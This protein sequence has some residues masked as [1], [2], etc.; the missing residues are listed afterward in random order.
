MNLPWPRVH[1]GP[2]AQ[3]PARHDFSTC[4][5]PA[6]PCPAAW[7][8]VQAA[9]VRH[10]PDPQH[11]A[12]RARL[13]QWHQV[14][15][16]R[17]LLAASA[18]EFIQRITAAALALA[19]GPVQL[20]RQAYG[21]YAAA[22]AAWGRPVQWSDAPHEAATDVAPNRLPAVG[23]AGPPALRWC[24]DLGS[25][26][27]HSQAVPEDLRPPGAPSAPPTV[28]DRAYT[29]LRLQGATP[30]HGTAADAVFQL[31]SPNKALGLTG[32]R[33]AYALAP[34]Q[35]HAALVAQLQALAP[36]WPLGAQGV[37]MLAAWCSAEVQA[38]LRQSLPGLRAQRAALVAGLQ[39]RGFGPLD[40]QASFV[41][42]QV[43][44]RWQEAQVA[45]PVAPP[46]TPP[47]T[48]PSAQV[49]ARPLAH[50]LRGH[51][52]AVRDAH[53]FGLPGHWRLNAL[54]EP[55]QQ[56]LWQALDTWPN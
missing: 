17:V 47:P 21:D 11:T 55:A 49:L 13:A 36:S 39:Q 10:Y 50:H 16:E 38:W 53:S 52:L 51:G 2:D 43:P 18:S 42:A 48:P 33:G 23:Q 15:P 14:A 30:W 41:C 37:A 28:L 12:L 56:A 35:G 31:Y 24:A 3:G 46:L 54:G 20:P 7:Q 32:V 40:G 19:P 44:D 9:D 26:A 22:A 29:P 27:G 45:H 25:P 1:G 8:A 6:G 34:A 5:H 4:S